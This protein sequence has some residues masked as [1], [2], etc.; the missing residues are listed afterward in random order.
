ML[1]FLIRR[2]AYALILVILVSFVSFAIIKLPP[3]DFLTQKLAQL[4]ARGDR[5]AESQIEQYRIR[6]GLDKS[7]WYQYSHWAVNF[8]KGDFGES[9]EYEKPVRALLG[10]RLTMTVILALS[11]LFVV[12]II[13]IPL[14]VYSAVKQYSLG[15]QVINHTQ[16]HRAGYAWFSIC[17]VI[18]IF[19]YQGSE[20]RGGRAVFAKIC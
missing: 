11:T 18:F 13:A 16:F 1:N 6:Y 19:C 10:E 7:F 3:G 15:D 12:W 14:G 2:V 17:P 20:Y 9:F 5:S 8:L 4:R